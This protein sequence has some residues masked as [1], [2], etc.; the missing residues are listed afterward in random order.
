MFKLSAEVTFMMGIL[1]ISTQNCDLLQKW[2]LFRICYKGM[3]INPEEEI[4]YTTQYK[5]AV[6]KHVENEH[7]AKHR[8]WPAINSE[9]VPSSNLFPSAK[10]SGSCQST[11]NSSHL[12]GDH[13]EY[14]TPR[15]GAETTPGWSDHTAH[16][17]I[18][19]RLFVNTAWIA[20]EL[21]A[22]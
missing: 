16:L 11:T 17:W 14:F 18:T 20:Q 9:T 13:Q 4:S 12:A 8:R 6:L 7:W 1:L 3:E 19:S 15:Q 10:A 2:W 21:G 22:S 5:V